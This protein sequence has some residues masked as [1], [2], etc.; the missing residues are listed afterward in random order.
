M[1]TILVVV[2]LCFLMGTWAGVVE[3]SE[4]QSTPK[5]FWF[6]SEDGTKTYPAITYGNG[7]RQLKQ[8]DIR[9]VKFYLYTL[10]N[11]TVGQELIPGDDTFLDASNFR[12]FT[13]T[14]IIS[15]GFT[16]SGLS[17]FPQE[18]KNKYM[19][20]GKDINV[21]TVDWQKFAEAPWYD[22][23][24]ANTRPVGQWSGSLVDHL[25][26]ARKIINI[27]QVHFIGHSLGSHVAGFCGAWIAPRIGQ[28][29]RI[30]A[31]D[32]ALPL[33]GIEGPEGRLDDTDAAFVDVFHTAG[34]T[35]VDG[36]LAF[37]DPLGHLDYYPN[38]G[39]PTQPGCGLDIAWTCSH[40][41]AHVYFGESVGTSSAFK[42]CKCASWED[43]DMGL[44]G[45]L[46]NCSNG[47]AVVMGEHTPTDHSVT[48][49]YYSYTND[50]SPFS[51]S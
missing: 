43:F 10:D 11:P 25:A 5:F 46:P 15:H 14:K 44:C 40:S 49:L 8:A 51:Q 34:G 1:R 4:G 35:L 3:R 41:R 45:F 31:L 38:D 47:P 28:I 26:N 36:G 50:K 13:E 42:S 20:Q 6:P 9:E 33:F 37:T 23:A 7:G 12:H 21:I 24:A 22:T 17:G 32:P 19:A 29:G 27:N 48:G 39:T 30:S 2:C 18:L 16:G